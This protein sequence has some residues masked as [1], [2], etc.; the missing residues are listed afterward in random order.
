MDEI[1]YYCIFQIF[2][3][4]YQ[5]DFSTSKDMAGKFV[6]KT[7]KICEYLA[8]VRKVVPNVYQRTKRNSLSIVKIDYYM[9]KVNSPS[10]GLM[11]KL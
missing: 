2:V 3:F 1:L 6:N 9:S 8:S 5:N 7:Q 4:T 10:K 11:L